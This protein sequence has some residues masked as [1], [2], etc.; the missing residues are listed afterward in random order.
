MLQTSASFVAS[1]DRV[2]A[3]DVGADMFL[4]EPMEAD[5]FIALV[6]ALLRLRAA[7]RKAAASDRRFHM[8]ARGAPVG[9]F[10]TDL[11]GGCTFV[12]DTWCHITGLSAAP[13]LGQAWRDAPHEDD[14]ERIVAAFA[15]AVAQ[16]APFAAEYRF[17]PHDG[18]VHWV[19]GQALPEFSDEGRLVGYIGSVT[20]I[21]ER[22]RIEEKLR[23]ADRIKDEFLAMLS[24]E[25]RN[26]LAP[27]RG[28]LEILRRRQDMAAVRSE[29]EVMDRQLRQ[30]TRL[31]DDL[32]DVAR[33]SHN[34]I[35]LK[36]ARIDLR[37]V[38]EAAVETSRPAIDRA[39]HVLALELPDQEVMVL[40]DAVRLSQVI[41]NLLNNAAKFNPPGGRV[42]VGVTCAR[43]QVSVRV[44]DNGVGM[45][46]EALAS[47]FEL[48]TQIERTPASGQGGL[49]IGLAVS[50]RIVELHEGTLTASS[51]DP[52][53][54]SEFVICLP[55]LVAGA[56]VEGPA[57][58][59]TASS[60][61]AARRIL[62][63]DD[64]EDARLS[65]AML[66]EMEGHRVCVAGDG[67]S[68]L[69]AAAELHPDTVLLDLGLPDMSGLEVARRLR[70]EEWGSD[71]LLVALTGW[72]RR[73][74]ASAHASG[75]DHHLV[76]P[77]ELGA[78][79]A[80]LAGAHR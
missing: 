23:E 53:L 58:A 69:H 37:T 73:P 31:T 70:G 32:F 24:H 59:R 15:Q 38:V 29:L 54:G 48:F 79:S 36:R 33:F 25:L 3:L 44:A 20:D 42:A 77:I 5:E 21:T 4:V 43:R 64:N 67:A 75:F 10:H 8:L 40:G 47:I 17:R 19:W 1:P 61:A 35:P 60:A 62:V 18:C 72:A 27:L 49:G 22:K 45:P 51:A 12:N 78:I 39:G 56:W 6:R 9:I 50:R 14:R 2:A 16:Q 26:P 41:A 71:L 57:P 52:D 34:R 66:L 55:L 11:A 46:R 63:V 65:L 30:L 28:M 7:E 80:V 76:K 74:T 13:G 68:A